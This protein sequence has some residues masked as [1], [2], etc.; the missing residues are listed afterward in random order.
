MSNFLKHL[1]LMS[2]TFLRRFFR[3]KIRVFWN[4]FGALTSFISF[5]VVWTAI[6]QGGF[7]G[8]GM[9]TRENY[10]VFLLTG[11]ITWTMIKSSVHD[12]SFHF[13][14][15][16]HRKTLAYIMMS[17]LN[18]I[19]Y[20]YSTLS[21]PMFNSLVKNVP[22]VIVASFFGFSFSGSVLL[23]I[24]VLLLIFISFSGL[25]IMLASLA[26]WREGLAHSA[27]AIMSI[28][29]LFSGVHYPL[30]VFPQPFED[31]FRL[32]PTT[33][34]IDAIRAIGLEGAGLMD[35]WGTV[36]YLVVFATISIALGIYVFRRMEK[37]AMYLGI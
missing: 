19:S 36:L 9:L 2:V 29:Y 31:I 11:S 37:K 20:L 24:L 26:A 18:R 32:L 8:L 27:T 6:L 4:V 17:P 1:K 10:L 16:K 7:Q 13:V 35:I 30:A 14:T 28:L 12:M 22:V 33:Q 21:Y 5:L 15:E 34:A 23:A 25:G 3:W